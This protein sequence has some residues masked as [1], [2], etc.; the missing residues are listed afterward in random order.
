MAQTLVA[1][2]TGHG[3]HLV[4][5]VPVAQVLPACKFPPVTGDVLGSNLAGNAIVG[6]LEHR[7]QRLD[8]VGVF[9]FLDVL[10]E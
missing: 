7:P 10:A 8:N 5:G 1:R 2:A 4:D 9:L 6:S 3:P